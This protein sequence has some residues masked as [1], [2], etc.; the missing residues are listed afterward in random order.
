MADEKDCAGCSLT[1]R[2]FYRKNTK[3]RSLDVPL[4]A[5]KTNFS[6][7]MQDKVDSDRGRKIYPQRFAVVEPV[8][9]NIKTQKRLN[10]FTLRGQDQGQHPMDALLHG[11]QY[12]KD[13]D[14]CYGI[15]GGVQLRR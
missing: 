5:D 4:G 2:C 13:H 7:L 3:R 1:Q 14:L 8:F 10:R 6:K 15:K 11:A 12:R 9:A